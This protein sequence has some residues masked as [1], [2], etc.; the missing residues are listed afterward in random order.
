MF[1]SAA[2][3]ARAFPLYSKKTSLSNKGATNSA[4]AEKKPVTV[5]VEYVLTGNNAS[6]LSEEECLML[7]QASESVRSAARIVDTPCNEM[8]TDHFLQVYCL[9]LF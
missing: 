8:N 1:P 5:F 2:A 3:V 4:S 6:P 7:Q 9:S